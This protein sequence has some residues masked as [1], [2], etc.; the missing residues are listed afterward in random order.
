[1]PLEQVVKLDQE[2][3]KVAGK[4]K[5][6]GVWEGVTETSEAAPQEGSDT[7][8][9]E[10]PII[11]VEAADDKPA[12][13]AKPS[14]ETQIHTS[15]S[16]ESGQSADSLQ[17]SAAPESEHDNADTVRAR[18]T[19]RSAP[20]HALSKCGRLCA[21]TGTNRDKLIRPARACARLQSAAVTRH[22]TTST[23]SVTTATASTLH[24]THRA[25]SARPS[26]CLR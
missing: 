3:R 23:L 17:P 16:A 11:A 10:V 4:A 7:P 6:T 9:Q 25:P 24:S 14:T 13:E 18:G 12:A 21:P 15:E 20:N 5:G 26:R 8:K 22:S 19:Q 2:V 1:M